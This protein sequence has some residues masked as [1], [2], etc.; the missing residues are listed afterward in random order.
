MRA[1]YKGIDFYSDSGD[2]TYTIEQITGWFEGVDVRRS[3]GA[4]PATDGVFDSPAYLTSRIITITGLVLSNGSSSDFEMALARLAGLPPRHVSL[5]TVETDNGTTWANAR[6]AE[7]PEVTV[8]VWGQVARYQLVLEA[9]DS[10]R[11]GDTHV[12]PPGT[13]ANVFH[14][15]NYE[16]SPII[17]VTAVTTMASGYTLNGPDGKA[18]VVTQGLTAGQVHRIDMATGWVYRNGVLQT[19]VVGAADL[20]GVPPGVLTPHAITPVSGTGQITVSV[21]DTFS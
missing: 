7:K 10:L 19:G 14:Y 12:S 21:T 11:Y 9:P 20:W 3:G 6:R 18:F 5:F 13:S 4:R 15:G 16:A 1:N 8:I 17:D 2:A